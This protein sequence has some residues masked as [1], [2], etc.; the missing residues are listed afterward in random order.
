MGGEGRGEEAE[1]LRQQL[2]LQM[3]PP[4]VREGDPEGGE[5]GGGGTLR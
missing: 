4:G 1:E 5:G 2:L 3:E